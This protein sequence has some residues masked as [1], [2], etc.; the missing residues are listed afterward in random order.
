MLRTSLARLRNYRRVG[1]TISAHS[2]TNI[3]QIIVSITVGQHLVIHLAVHQIRDSLLVFF[4][5]KVEIRVP[6]V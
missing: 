5:I 3:T 1:T 6:E 2:T 4:R